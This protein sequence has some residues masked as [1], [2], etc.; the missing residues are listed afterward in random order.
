M[1]ARMFG[2]VLW[3]NASDSK[4]VV[5][6]ED[7]GNLAYYAGHQDCPSHDGIALD[8][9]DLIEFDM[10]EEADLR[11]VRNPALVDAGH[12]P[13]LAQDLKKAT[14]QTRP[15]VR[16]GPADTAQVIAFRPRRARPLYLAEA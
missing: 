6:C 8:A 7:Q 2:V 13:M 15:P 10:R 16:S 9:G 5:W 11:L 3:A 4:A 12:A 1:A 14:P